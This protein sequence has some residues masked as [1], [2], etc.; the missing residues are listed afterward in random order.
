MKGDFTRTTFRSDKHY[1]S[2]RM[3]QGRVQLDAD[4]NEQLDIA[5]HRTETGAVDTIGV[6]GAPMHNAGFGLIEGALPKITIGHY[7]VDG[8]LCEN[9]AE[10]DIDDQP[11]LKGFNL[12]KTEGYYLAYLDVWQHHI[13]ALEDDDIREVALGGP[14]TATRTKTVWQVKLIGPLQTKLTC[15]SELDEWKKLIDPDKGEMGAWAPP[16]TVEEGPCVVPPGAGYRRLE[17]QLYRVEIHQAG[18]LGV[19]KFKWSRDNG[20]IVTKWLD[21]KGGD[22]TVSSIGRDNVL[23]FASGQTVEVTDDN[24]DL[25]GQAGILV[26]LAN[27]EGQILT[28]DPT[29]TATDTIKIKDFPKNPKVRRWDSDGAIATSADWIPLD[30]DGVKVAFKPGYYSVGD[31]WLIPAR[32]AKGDVEWPQDDAKKPKFQP[33]AGIEHHYCRLAVLMYDGKVFHRV[34]DCRQFFPPQTE[35]SRFFYVGGDGQEA[36]PGKALPQLMQVG[37]VNGPQPVKDAQV[38]FRA[39]DSLGR[40]ALNVATLAD[41][42]ATNAAV[43]KTGADGVASCAWLPEANVVKPSQQLVATLLDCAGNATPHPAIHFTANLSI[44]REVAYDPAKCN[45]LA[46]K[47]NVQ[48]AIDTL[49]QIKV[50][51]GCGITVGKGGQF[52]KLEEAIE[53]LLGQKLSNICICLLPGDLHVTSGITVKADIK[54]NPLHLKI[55]GCAGSRVIADGPWIFESLA[56]FTLTNVEVIV[57]LVQGRAGFILFNHCAEVAIE[58]CRL[59]AVAKQGALLQIDRADRI[60]FENSMIEVYHEESMEFPRK[61]FGNTPV[62]KLFDIVSRRDFIQAAF[63]VSRLELASVSLKERKSIADKVGQLVEA[64]RELSPPERESYEDIGTGLRA[65]TVNEVA[66]ARSL[67]KIRDASTKRA[68]GTAIIIGDGDAE[69]TFEDNHI[70]G[71]V[72]IYGSP[73][74][75]PLAEKKLGELL[76]KLRETQI[77]FSGSGILQVRGNRLSQM[78]VGKDVIERL[79]KVAVDR[80]GKLSGLFRTTFFTDNLFE[81]ANNQLIASNVELTSNAFEP[82]SGSGTV[83]VMAGETAIFVGNRGTGKKLRLLHLTDNSQ[84][85]ANLALTIVKV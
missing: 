30:Q 8:I 29:D 72:S 22:L 85:A 1:S 32:T 3:Q 79:E 10:V 82:I 59:V 2:V 63:N 60:Y 46:G 71:T 45:N 4:W 16:G 77:S 47:T 6:C 73:S 54:K 44:A 57:P 51:V 56:S 14:D 15:L 31:Y 9:E 67:L 69:A 80:K 39:N 19:A 24:R 75:V 49:C 18:N 28:L 48:D 70:W 43:V 52:K 83:V 35:L 33:R 26:K 81:A 55:K 7:Y 41:P 21:Q 53:S 76:V 64:N 66:F 84:E 40:V 50:G 78:V 38:C 74:A 58:S 17:N 42:N 23:N 13:T 27:A 20:S 61:V 62:A 5:A 12:D 68:P 34:T 25:N 36:M 37:V 65:S 11:D